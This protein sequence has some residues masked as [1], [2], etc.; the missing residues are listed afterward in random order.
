MAESEDES[1]GGGVAGNCGD[2]G[3]REREES[4]DKRLE[5][6]DHVVEAIASGGG[7][8]GGLSPT[9]VEAIGEEPA[10]G[11]GYENGA[12]D[13]LRLNLGESCDER[14]DEGWAETVFVVAGE[15]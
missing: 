12:T 8:T 2:G 6:F 10:V 3:H 11:G 13:G 1:S 9:K 5:A 15:G 4:G 14:V 7:G